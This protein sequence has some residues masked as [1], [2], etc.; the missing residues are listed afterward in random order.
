[1]KVDRSVRAARV[2]EIQAIA[3]Y[4]AEVFWIRET[5]RRTLLLSVLE[6]ER[7][8][9]SELRPW[10]EVRAL[11]VLTNRIFGWLFGTLLAVLPWTL[12]CRVQAWAEEE[13]AKIYERASKKTG[14]NEPELKARLLSAHAQELKHAARFRA[15]ISP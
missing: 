9:D 6:E 2:A 12:M 7:V 13:A 10:V 8:H 1:M 11:S 14:A 4:E 3:I 15:L 5:S